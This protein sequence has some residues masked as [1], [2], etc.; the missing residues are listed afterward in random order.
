MGVKHLTSEDLS[1]ERHGCEL[2]VVSRTCVRYL[3]RLQPDELCLREEIR[4]L[5]HRH[6]RYGDLS[7]EKDTNQNV[8]MVG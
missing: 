7:P 5:A 4:T 6:K 2:A 8:S 3:P 1:S